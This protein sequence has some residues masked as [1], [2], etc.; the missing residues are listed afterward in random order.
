MTNDS[1]RVRAVNRY[2]IQ[3]RSAHMQSPHSVV[4]GTNLLLPSPGMEEM[5]DNILAILH[6]K[7][8]ENGHPNTFELCKMKLTKFPSGEHEPE[9]LE[10]V[11]G[12]TVFSLHPMQLP[13]P[14]TGLVN[15]ILMNDALVSADVYKIKLVLPFIPFQRN[16]RRKDN[17]RVSISARAVAKVVQAYSEVRQVITLDL[18]ADQEVGLYNIPVDNIGATTVFLKDIRR[19]HH[20]D[21]SNIIAV[22]PDVGSANRSRRIARKLDV[23]LAII[24]KDRE[25]PGNSKVLGITGTSVRGKDAKLFDDIIDTGGTIIN[26]A[27]KLVEEGAKSVEVFGIHGLFSADATEKFAKAGFQVRVTDS[28]PQSAEFR[29]KHASWLT[30]VS[31]DELLANAIYA[32]SVMRGSIPK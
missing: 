6:K 1:G 11:R 21:L 31:V 28:I 14:N 7:S 5:A 8:E 12:A 9:I 27:R 15:L 20:N 18:H 29:A 19:R 25:G 4:F 22:S 32:A 10:P 30:Y 24:D 23:P 3:P 17:K 16:D 26:A 2:L 13:D